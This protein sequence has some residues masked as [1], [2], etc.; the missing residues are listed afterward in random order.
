MTSN[1]DKPHPGARLW[2]R[3]PRLAKC[4]VAAPL[5]MVLLGAEISLSLSPSIDVLVTAGGAWALW[6]WLSS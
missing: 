2:N 6:G 1:T 5:T 3:L 4:A